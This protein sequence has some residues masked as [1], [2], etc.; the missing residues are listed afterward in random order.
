M[1]EYLEGGLSLKQHHR[2]AQHEA[3]CPDCAR[4]IA[5]LNA[6]LTVL[7]SLQL[8]PTASF[9]I[10]ERTANHVRARIGEWS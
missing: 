6:L 10:A 1:S 2:L 5:T 7:P 8:S 3:L 9:E 4:L